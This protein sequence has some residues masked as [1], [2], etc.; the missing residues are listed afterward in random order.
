MEGSP[1]KNHEDHIAGKGNITA[2]KTTRW[3]FVV[4]RET[5][6]KTNDLQA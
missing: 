2:E 5:D 1:H 3:V 4:R 6:K